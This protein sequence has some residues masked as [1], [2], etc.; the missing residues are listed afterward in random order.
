MRSLLPL[1]AA[2]GLALPVRAWGQPTGDG[3][4]LGVTDPEAL[5]HFERAQAHFEAKRFSEAAAEL[6]AAYA[7]EPDAALLYGWA[8]AERF[9]GNCKKAVP[10]YARYLDTRPDEESA[11]AAEASIVMCAGKIGDEPEPGAKTVDPETDE[12]SDDEEEIKPAYRD[13]L[14]AT[15]IALGVATG[16]AGGVLLGVGRQEVMDSAAAP[17]EDDYF[18][19]VAAGRT[20][21]TAG[22]ALLGVSGALVLSAV[23]RYSVLAGKNRKKR[24]AEASVL[25]PQRGLG[26]GLKVR[27]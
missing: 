12:G 25:V 7:I 24:K 4:G 8:Q 22:I 20:K 15:F 16:I 23:I 9:A 3:G 10:L 5:E 13:W 14:G 18:G 11:R 6:E 26:L 21:H 1:V 2:L 17:T 27:F 19:E